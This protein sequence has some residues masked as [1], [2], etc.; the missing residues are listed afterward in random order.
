VQRPYKQRTQLPAPAVL[1]GLGQERSHQN[2]SFHE[3]YS[4]GQSGGQWPSYCQSYGHLRPFTIINIILEHIYKSF[5]Q[6]FLL[7]LY[8]FCL[9][10][11]FCFGCLI[12]TCIS[13][14]KD[15][16]KAQGKGPQ[17]VMT[18]L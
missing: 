16:R 18:K 1:Y 11:C 4:D 9:F 6:S 12:Q 17:P 2:Q 7:F 3:Y 14:K 15:R 5:L 8:S 13:V 10:E